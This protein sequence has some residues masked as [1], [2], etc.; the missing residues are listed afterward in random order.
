MKNIT[1]GKIFFTKTQEALNGLDYVNTVGNNDYYEA[2]KRD[3]YDG[4]IFCNK[5]KKRIHAGK[6]KLGMRYIAHNGK[7]NSSSK[8]NNFAYATKTVQLMRQSIYFGEG[9]FHDEL[10]NELLNFFKKDDRLINVI[11]E[12]FV[13]SESDKY[14]N[15][16]RKRRKPDISGIIKEKTVAIELQLSYQLDVDYFGREV[17]YENMNGFLL[18]F[19]YDVKRSDF[20]E[21]QKVIFYNSGENAY[22]I[23]E[24]TRLKSKE[25]GKLF[26]WCYYSS[27]EE[28]KII[29]RQK[30][31]SFDEIIFDFKRSKAYYV[32]IAMQRAYYDAL[33][34]QKILLEEMKD[35]S[36]DMKFSKKTLHM[37]NSFS[38]EKLQHSYYKFITLLWTIFSLK[39]N[40]VIGYKFKNLRA[41]LN[42]RFEYSKEYGDLTLL[43]LDVYGRL[44]ELKVDKKFDILEKKLKKYENERVE[45]DKYYDNII[46]KIFPELDSQL[47][48]KEK[49]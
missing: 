47:D 24:E 15:G 42:Q 21:S 16:A 19:L 5:C 36:Q 23:T 14:E 44:D 35:N 49:K 29:N 37:I 6:S 39:N 30:I 41:L 31:I 11:G 17:F 38:I 1:D 9:T 18:W 25:E 2:F 43:A 33:K 10:K 45:Q 13:Y 22:V 28:E 27:F 48:L 40:E 46:Y 32:D 12:S 34:F 8:C 20:T 26:F 4:V 3:C 7:V